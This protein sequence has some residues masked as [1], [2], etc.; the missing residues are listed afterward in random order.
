[1][2]RSNEQRI[3]SIA[4][5]ITTMIILPTQMG[6]CPGM[7]STLPGGS[8]LTGVT[9][10]TPAEAYN[11]IQEHRDDPDFIILDVRTAEEYADGHIEG[12]VNI[13]SACTASFTNAL[14]TL[15]TSATYLVHCRSGARSTN[16][17]RVMQESGFTNI[18]HLA[19]GLNQWIADGYPT[20]QSE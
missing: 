18:Y 12:A 3:V 4:A 10:V 2:M 16:A 6:G 7:A 19:A 8:T 17:I 11:L 15:D 13:C 9:D 14:A 1:M 5:A 20:I